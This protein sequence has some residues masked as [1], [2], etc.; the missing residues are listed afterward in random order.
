MIRAILCLIVAS[1]A[2]ARLTDAKPARPRC[3]VVLPRPLVPDPSGATHPVDRVE[4]K[5]NG[6]DSFW[7]GVEE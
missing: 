1:F 4:V 5:I 2:I 6:E 3:T 7:C